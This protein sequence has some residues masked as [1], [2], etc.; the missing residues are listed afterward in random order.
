MP[1]RAVARWWAAGL[2]F[3]VI[4]LANLYVLIEVLRIRL[5]VSTLVSAEVTAIVRYAINDRWI[6]GEHHPS[7]KRFCQFPVAN[8]GGCCATPWNPILG[9]V[10]R[11]FSRRRVV[12][13]VQQL[14]LDLAKTA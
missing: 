4:G 3:L 13:H 10:C 11:G 12:Q 8:A 1:C 7:W 14:P 2:A 5:F 9:G 6:F